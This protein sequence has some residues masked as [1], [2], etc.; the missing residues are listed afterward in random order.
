MGIALLKKLNANLP[1]FIKVALAPIIRRKLI[2]S[3][4]FQNQMKELELMDTLSEEEVKRVQ[5]EKLKETLVH[6]YEHTKYYRE[7]F[8]NV[9]FDV[10]SFASK[11][12][13]DIIPVLTKEDIRNNFEALQADDISDYYSATTGGSTGMPLKVL[14]DRESIY[15]ERAFIYHFWSKYGYDYK[16][17]KIAS[18]RGTDFKGKN[19]KANPLYA[20]IQFNPCN[21]NADTIKSYYKKMTSFGVDFLQGFPSAIYSFCCFARDAGLDVK[22]KYKAVLCAS[23]NVYDFQKKVIEEVLGCKVIS[24]Y[25]H[26]ERAVFAEQYGDAYKFNDYYGYWEINDAGNVVCTGFISTKMPLIRYEVDDSVFKNGDLYSIKGHRDGVMYGINGEIISAAA[27]NL[28]TDRLNKSI[29]FQLHQKEKGVLIVR[30]VPFGKLKFKEIEE[31]RDIFQ[32]QAG[33]NLT[34]QI[35]IAKEMILTQRGKYKLLIQE[36]K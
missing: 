33:K 26:S 17:S 1:D 18:F 24:F 28:H 12:Q 14:L 4:V 19:F 29:N 16:K 20:E 11:E 6:A 35:E 34:I 15:R 25:G 22:G 23:E 5:F 21:I 32:R 8:D 27:M 31:I 36:I 13:L 10:Y 7:L 30:I 9:G 2:N 3:S